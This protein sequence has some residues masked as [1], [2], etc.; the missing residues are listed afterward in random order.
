[1]LAVPKFKK[2]EIS[3]QFFYQLISFSI[4]QSHCIFIGVFRDEN[5]VADSGYFYADL[6]S[7]SSKFKLFIL[8]S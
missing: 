3:F 5:R 1:M 2:N 4:K 7:G 8:I 6:L